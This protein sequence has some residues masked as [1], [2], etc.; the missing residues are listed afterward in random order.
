MDGEIDTVIEKFKCLVEEEIDYSQPFDLLHATMQLKKKMKDA[1]T[2]DKLKAR[3]CICGN[4]LNEVEGETYSPTVAP[5]THS[6]MLQLAV[7]DRMFIQL[8]DTVAAYLNQD[9]P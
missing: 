3:I 2:V 4:E 8:V 6:F 7:H 1:V 9:Y 5:L